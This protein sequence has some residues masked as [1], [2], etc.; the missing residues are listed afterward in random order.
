M[1]KVLLIIVF[2]I[3]LT[4][5]FYIA[6]HIGWS[7]AFS[8]GLLSKAHEDFD[9]S[10]GCSSCHTQSKGLDNKKC[11]G[12]HEEIKVKIKAGQGLHAKISHECSQ[13]HSEHHGR[14]YGLIHFDKETFDHTTTGWQLEGKHT[15]LKC[16]TCHQSDTYLLDKT[17]CV[18][19]H[20]DVHEGENGKDCG[21]CH[22]Q[23]SFDE[24]S[25]S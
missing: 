21:E 15:L 18:Q 20:Q 8:P 11:V 17:D 19:C 7:R 9:T 2:I 5:S 10:A 1:K 22:N 23:N 14:G 24:I 6:S 12:C 25:D 16:T 4:C 13:C 3:V